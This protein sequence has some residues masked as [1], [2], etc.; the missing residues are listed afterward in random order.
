M[1]CRRQGSTDKVD[2]KDYCHDHIRRQRQTECPRSTRPGI[3]DMTTKWPSTADPPI[4]IR[5]MQ[6]MRNDSRTDFCKTFGIQVPLQQGEQEDRDGTDTACFGG[7]KRIL[8]A[9]LSTVT[10]K[11]S[12]GQR[13]CGIDRARS[14]Q[15]EDCPWAQA[16]DSPGTTLQS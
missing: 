16:M 7:S 12:R 13:I 10:A 3:F 1:P 8:P 4:S 6:P 5:T 15:L 2:E 14:F 9:G 11:I